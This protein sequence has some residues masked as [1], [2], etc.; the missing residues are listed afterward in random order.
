M[1]TC[2]WTVSLQT[3]MSLLLCCGAMFGASIT[4]GP[5]LMSTVSD[6]WSD[7]IAVSF[8]AHVHHCHLSFVQ[9]CAN[10][11]DVKS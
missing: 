5:V 4:F 10:V 7:T 2:K 8:A 9:S 3:K 11:T 1:R 6:N